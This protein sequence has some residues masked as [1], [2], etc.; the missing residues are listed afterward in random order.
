M[1]RLSEFKDKIN[2]KQGTIEFNISNENLFSDNSQTKIIDEVLVHDTKFALH[3][4]KDM[5]LIFSHTSPDH[6]RRLSKL[7]LDDVGNAQRY[8]I[9]F[10]WS[11]DKVIL[12]IGAF[13]VESRGLIIGDFEK[14]NSITA[15]QMTSTFSYEI[16]DFLQNNN[17][18]DISTDELKE[19]FSQHDDI[20]KLDES[21]ESP[22]IC[23]K[24]FDE[25]YIFAEAQPTIATKTILIMSARKIP[26][27]F[28]DTLSEKNFATIISSFHEKVAENF[29]WKTK[30][31]DDVD[32]KKELAIIAFSSVIY[33]HKYRNF[34]REYS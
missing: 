32:H 18:A 15:E 19:V 5:M 24:Y 28:I 10:T 33:E 20:I 2:P 16:F 23:A 30:I 12:Y 31:L 4:T 14:I 8:S 9:T 22:L 3:R 34:L 25:Y 1:S 27:K 26:N 21:D 29:T 13:G 7:N 17:F 6:G 11:D